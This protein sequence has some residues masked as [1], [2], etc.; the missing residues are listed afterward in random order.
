MS[1]QEKYESDQ[2]RKAAE[3]V[4]KSKRDYETPDLLN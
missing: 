2:E 3:N 1:G 4:A